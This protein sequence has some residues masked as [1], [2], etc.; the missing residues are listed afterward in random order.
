MEYYSPHMILNQRNW[1]YNKHFQY[2]FG[3]YVRASQEENPTNTNLVC[4]VD[5]I[6][7][8]PYTNLQRVHKLMDISTGRLIT[9][10]KVNP[11][12]ITKI[13]LKAVEKLAESQGF[14]NIK[15]KIAI[16]GKFLFLVMILSQEWTGCIMKIK[17]MISKRMKIN[18][19]LIKMKLI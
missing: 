6:F 16:R 17:Y 9:Q 5:T 14:K 3:S 19:I 1:D 18:N 4:T 15:N 11:C 8:C 2:G 10:P 12:L 13:F 7:L